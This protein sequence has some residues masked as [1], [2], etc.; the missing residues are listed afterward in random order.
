MTVGVGDVEI[1][2]TPGRVA[3][4]GFG[5][6]PSIDYAEVDRVN[7]VHVKYGPAPPGPAAFWREHQVQVTGSDAEAGERGATATVRR[8]QPESHLIKSHRPGHVLHRQSDG[9]YVADYQIVFPLNACR[10]TIFNEIVVLV[11][12]MVRFYVEYM[13]SILRGSGKGAVAAAR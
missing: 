11:L 8:V 3:G 4:G 10:D 12:V 6:Q 7:V 5:F 9:A 1:A 2:F 13:L